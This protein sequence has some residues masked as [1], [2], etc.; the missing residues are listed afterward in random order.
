[1]PSIIRPLLRWGLVGVIALGGATLLVGPDVMSAGVHHVRSKASSLVGSFVDDPAALRRQLVALG[2][3]Y[4]DRIA[5]VRGELASVQRQIEQLE[6]DTEV[7]RRVVVN[8][9]ADLADL[10]DLIA[11]AESTATAKGVPVAI[12]TRGVRLDLDAAHAEARRVGDIR[13]A[14]EDRA[15]A[16]E[17]QL[18]ILGEQ[19]H[20][21]EE[22]LGRLQSE[23]GEFELKLAQIDRQIDAIERNERLIDMTRQQKAALAQYEKFGRLG[24]LSQLEAKLA[25]LSAVQEAQFEAL[26]RAGI[27]RDYERTARRELDRGSRSDRLDALPASTPATTPALRSVARAETV[28]IERR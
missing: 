16:N 17:H 9:G 11:E 18:R 12:R 13:L 25:E 19:R 8:A 15:A 24:N 22:I 3:E 27:D 1:M 6:H 14:Y 28:V 21:L 7:A 20:R 26:S 2:A 5:A 10:R 23:Y 4:P